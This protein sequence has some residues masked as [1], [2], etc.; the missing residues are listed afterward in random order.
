MVVVV[1]MVTGGAAVV[2]MGQV[3]GPLGVGLGVVMGGWD[4]MGVG[5]GA[6]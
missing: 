2:V 5:W 4:R 1:V 6:P 3:M